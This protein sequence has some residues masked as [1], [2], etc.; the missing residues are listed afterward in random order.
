MKKIF[1]VILLVAFC[2][3]LLSACGSRKP[4]TVGLFGSVETP[5]QTLEFFEDGRVAYSTPSGT[6]SFMG[7]YKPYEGDNEEFD[8]KYSYS[9]FN[10][11]YGDSEGLVIFDPSYDILLGYTYYHEDNYTRIR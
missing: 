6:N 4:K 2:T 1:K 7:T 8:K 11:E 5:G 9:L 10:D 3:I